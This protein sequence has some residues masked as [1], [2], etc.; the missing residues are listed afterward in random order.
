M[1]CVEHFIGSEMILHLMEH[2]VDL[3]HVKSRFSL[4]GN[5]VSVSAK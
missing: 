1:V 5:D 4:F 2:M 3:G